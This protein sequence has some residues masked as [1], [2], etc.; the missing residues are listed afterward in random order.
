MFTK[1]EINTYPYPEE[2]SRVEPKKNLF[3][4]KTDL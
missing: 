2:E 3:I 4:Q 1:Y